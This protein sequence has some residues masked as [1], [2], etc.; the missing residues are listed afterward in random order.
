M[1]TVAALQKAIATNE[2]YAAN[3]RKAGK[4]PAKYV[5]KIAA[6]KAELAA[7]APA[8]AA[9]A[10]ASSGLTNWAAAQIDAGFV[11]RASLGDT[12]G[13]DTNPAPGAAKALGFSGVVGTGTGA[14]TIYGT[15]TNG[16][17]ASSGPTNPGD[18]PTGF[19]TP[20][21]LAPGVNQDAPYSGPGAAR[22]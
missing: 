20:F 17:L 3:Y 22:P 12:I 8:K 1:A 2:R 21:S 9:A 14:A 7:A 5:A 6:L 4:N 13:A 16:A 15:F 11:L 19:T 18:S 10:P